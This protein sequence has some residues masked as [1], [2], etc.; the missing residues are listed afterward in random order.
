MSESA[1]EQAIVRITSLRIATSEI[2]RGKNRRMEHRFTVYGVDASGNERVYVEHADEQEH[3]AWRASDPLWREAQSAMFDRLLA[4]PGTR[5]TVLQ[6]NIASALKKGDAE[7]AAALARGLSPKRFQELFGGLSVPSVPRK[8]ADEER[9]EPQRA[10]GQAP[11]GLMPTE[12]AMGAESMAATVRG[13]VVKVLEAHRPLL[14]LAVR[15]RAKLEGWL[16]FELAARTEQEGFGPVQVAAGYGEGRA[17]ITLHRGTERYDL[18]LKTPNTNW[19]V[20]GVETK[21]RP[22]TKNFAG[23]VADAHK[24]AAAPG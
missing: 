13:W 10:E 22:V 1:S 12:L 18:E 7:T 3:E 8:G 20:P 19:R 4:N 15:Q 2:G 24:L 5:D 16:K 21:H 9:T 11:S 14:A 17:D 6:I 23:V